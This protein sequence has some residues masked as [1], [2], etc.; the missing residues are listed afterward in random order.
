MTVTNPVRFLGLMFIIVIISMAG[1]GC[2]VPH[3]EPIIEYI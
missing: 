2:T 1:E 3:I